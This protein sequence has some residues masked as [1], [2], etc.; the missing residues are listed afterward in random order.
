MTSGVIESVRSGCALIINADDWGR[1]RETTDKILDCIESGSV[2][3]TSAMVF[4]EDSERAASISREHEIDTGIHL[5]FTTPF[6]GVTCGSKKLCEHQEK[7]SRFLLRSRIAQV[8]YNPLLTNS[9]HYVVEAQIEE[10]ARL[11]GKDPM[12]IDGHHHMHLCANVLFGRLLP[13]GTIVRRSFSKFSGEKGFINRSWRN[14]VN[15]R[16]ARRHRITDHFFSIEP[17]NPEHLEALVNLGSHSIVEIETHPVNAEEYDFLVSG[18]LRKFSSTSRVSS[19][20]QCF[21]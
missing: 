16:L 20:S 21:N 10:Y 13:E 2:T 4:M 19:F 17:L 1:N 5:N 14:F 3:A 15:S 12:R 8:L 11:Y 18:G 6:S 9:F 7:I